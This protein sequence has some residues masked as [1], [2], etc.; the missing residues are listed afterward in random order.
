MKC[1]RFKYLEIFNE[2]LIHL[3]KKLLKYLC[4]FK[5]NS[6]KIIFY[7]HTGK[8]I[9]KS[10]VVVFTLKIYMKHKYMVL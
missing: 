6:N 1:L 4:N 3:L 7:I 5:L 2:N 8:Y 9:Y 10:C